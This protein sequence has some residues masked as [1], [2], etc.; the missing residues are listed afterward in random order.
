MEN[1]F[2]PSSPV[3][4]LRSV[5]VVDMKVEVEVVEVDEVDS[6]MIEV[7]VVDTIDTLD[8]LSS[9]TSMLSLRYTDRRVVHTWVHLNTVCPRVITPIHLSTSTMDIMDT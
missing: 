3:K 5:T 7:E 1:E 6:E 2:S 8:D 9:S 4:T